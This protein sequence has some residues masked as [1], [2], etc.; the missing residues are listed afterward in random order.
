MPSAPSSLPSGSST[1][2]ASRSSCRSSRPIS[3]TASIGIATGIPASA[4][5]LLQDADLALYKAK[6]MGKDGYAL[7]ESAMHTVAQD[8][9]PLDIDLANALG[10]EQFFLVYQPIQIG[11]A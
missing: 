5:H 1:C 7:F 10:A 4:E 6:A 3:V 2:C 9:I 11:R 8:R